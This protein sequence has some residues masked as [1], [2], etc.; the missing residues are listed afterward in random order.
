M[1]KIIKFFGF[2][3]NCFLIIIFQSCNSDIQGEKEKL[4]TITTLALKDITQNT[5]TCGGL[6]TSDGG[7]EVSLRGV[8][9][10]LKPNPTINDS[11]TK[12]AAGTGEYIS[13]ITNLIADTTYYL[14]AY[15][16]NNTGTSYGLQVSFR[17]LKS[18]LPTIQT[19]TI[20]EISYTS[21]ISGGNI[22]DNGGSPILAKGICWSTKVNPNVQNEKT[23][24]G[25]GLG[26]FESKMNNLIYDTK[27]YVRAYATNIVGTAYGNELE[28][29]TNSYVTG[30]ILNH[31]ALTVGSGK[32]T[33]L[34]ATILPINTAGEVIWSSENNGIATVTNGIVTGINK[35]VTKI[36]ASVGSISS[37]CIVTVT[38]SPLTGSEYFL[39]SLDNATAAKLG[40]KIKV[41]FRPDNEKRI[42]YIWDNSFITV[43][44]SG[45]NFFG[46][47]EDWTSLVVGSNGWS[48]G[49][50]YVQDAAIID[51]LAL[52][53]A[54][55]TGYYL[56]IGIKSKSNQ[57]FVF[58]LDGQ[59][60]TKFAVGATAFNDN[61]T[62][63]QPLTN[64]TRDGE[65]QEI[66]IPMST[67]KTNGLLY[68]AGMG[69]KNILW[70]LAGGITGTE[71][72]ID[73]V[74]IY[75]K[76]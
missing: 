5:A 13:Y 20:N 37:K 14:R 18:N 75:K 19:L 28:F 34:T 10:S 68:V 56:H 52:I 58:G 66:E 45:S 59:S 23:S 11:T 44:S 22:I 72:N 32:S 63:I 4:P 39:I 54:N 1:N 29:Q 71:L 65:W 53:N 51:K 33:A 70:F 73:A 64:F 62:L 35:G 6:I 7:I 74:F 50:F 25:F 36:V 47:V 49:G 43:P 60:N 24:E 9:W 30:I 26:V 16:T 27:Y 31:S 57:V 69:A 42:L 15:A 3:I 40:N 55:P 61:G 46:E 48:G 21:A 67:L 41:D 38:G 12:D 76:P 2:L 8:C 17:T